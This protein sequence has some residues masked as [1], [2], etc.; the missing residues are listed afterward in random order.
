MADDIDQP[1]GG[2]GSQIDTGEY[3]ITSGSAGVINFYFPVTVEVRTEIAA[4]DTEALVELALA[5]LAEGFE[6]A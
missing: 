2:A 5:R 4:V 1:G 6:S 3:V